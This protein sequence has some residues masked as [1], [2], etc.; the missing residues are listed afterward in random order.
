V[1][2]DPHRFVGDDKGLFVVGE[3]GRSAA[4]WLA[5]SCSV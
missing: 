2:A 3:I 5:A 1:S 4:N